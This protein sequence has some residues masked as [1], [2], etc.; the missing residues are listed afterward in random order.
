ML[1]IMLLMMQKME[2]ALYLIFPFLIGVPAMLLAALVFVPV[3]YRLD[4]M[5]AAGWKTL[6][7]PLVGGLV[8]MA[9]M[10]TIRLSMGQM[11][12][13]VKAMLLPGLAVNFLLGAILGLLWRL[14]DWIYARV[15]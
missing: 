15:F 11:S 12:A 5:G 10:L 1:P 4:G 14:S 13:E 2:N 9:A 8:F 6:V 7:V 3:E